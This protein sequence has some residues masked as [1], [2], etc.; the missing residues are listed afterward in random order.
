MFL[1]SRIECAI[2]I[3][4]V[5]Q[6]VKLCARLQVLI[7]SNAS[8]EGLMVKSN[9]RLVGLVLLGFACCVFAQVAE[10]APGENVLPSPPPGKCLILRKAW[11]VA[12]G[13][14]KFDLIVRNGYVLWRIYGTL[15]E[16]SFFE[17]E[18]LESCGDVVSDKLDISDVRILPG[19]NG[20]KRVTYKVALDSGGKC[21]LTVRSTL[22][23]N[24]YDESYYFPFSVIRRCTEPACMGRSI[25]WEARSQVEKFLTK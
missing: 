7:S 18:E 20:V 5:V 12:P 8:I 13:V 4:K 24:A 9:C 19:R 6:T 25:G 15:D 3:P 21:K 14:E 22:G 11:C 1:A 2:G 23:E 17:I 10:A 16:K